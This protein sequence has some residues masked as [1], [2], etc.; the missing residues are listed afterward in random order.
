MPEENE[1]DGLVGPVVAETALLAVRV[2]EYEA[3][4]SGLIH[5][6]RIAARSGLE[7]CEHLIEG[8]VIDG[9]SVEVRVAND[10]A[11]PHHERQPSWKTRLPAMWILCPRRLVR[12]VSR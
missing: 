4:Q 5:S 10:V 1:N 2:F 3:G 7:R 6:G 11:G 8:R 9:G 12:I